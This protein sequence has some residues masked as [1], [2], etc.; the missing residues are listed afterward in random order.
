MQH[1]VKQG[2][3]L[4]SIAHKYGFRDYKLVYNHPD[5]A[6]FRKKRPNPNLIFPGD[7][8]NIPD[9]DPKQTKVVTNHKHKFVLRGARRLLR[10]RFL[11][12][13]GKPIANAQMDV[14][15]DDD[16]SRKQSTDGKGIVEIAVKPD[17]SAAIL[18]LGKHAVQLS[19]NHLNP[20]E[21][22]DDAGI[23]GVQARLYNLG[24]YRGAITDELDLPTQTAIALFQ[25]DFKLEINGK[26]DDST[27]DKLLD[28]HGC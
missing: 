26:P 7:V 17:A 16:S 9:K 28:E 3:C 22:T 25:H 4:S 10:L 14:T 15:I 8:L 2:E 6:A 18:K 21:D 23:S 1:T 27:I 5:N 12:G 24:Y 19:L 13:S 11:D 20:I